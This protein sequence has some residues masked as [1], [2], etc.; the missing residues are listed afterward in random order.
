MKVGDKLGAGDWTISPEDVELVNPM[1]GALKTL[2]D[3]K[4]QED[5]EKNERQK[6]KRAETKRK[7][8]EGGT[9]D[10]LAKRAR[11]VPGSYKT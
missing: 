9:S 8:S 1:E 3:A 5:R 2:V 4:K 11:M 7:Q 6:K 10:T